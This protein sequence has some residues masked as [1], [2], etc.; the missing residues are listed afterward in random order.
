MCDILIGL[1]PVV[2]FAL[3]EFT[4]HAAVNILLS[5]AVMVLAEFV[6]VLIK[7]WGP[8]DNEKHP[9]KEKFL[10]AL[11]GY[12]INNFLVPS[13]SAVIFALLMPAQN[14]TNPG[15]IYFIIVLGALFGIIIGK[16]VFGGTGQNIFNPAAVGFIFTKI[17][18]PG[19]F[20]SSSWYAASTYNVTAG[21]TY[22][23]DKTANLSVLDLFLGHSDG[24]M[25]EICKY[26]ILIGLVYLLIRHTVD[27]RVVLSF[28]GTFA[29]YLAIESA[30]Y[31]G[32]HQAS[33]GDF[34]L[35]QLLSGGVIFGGV[36]MLTDPVTMPVTRPSRVMYGI[37][38]A[39]STIF[40]RAF[41][42]APEGMAYS[43]LIGNMLAPVMDYYKWSQTRFTWKYLLAMGIVLLIGSGALIWA[44]CDRMT[45]AYTPTSLSILLGGN[46]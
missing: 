12:S 2:I 40:I 44:L 34:F 41:A 19:K 3:I 35:K 31:A 43:I 1:S 4:W 36:Y 5:V 33:F 30:I 11:K 38:V 23:S 29:F 14:T 9:F 15:D 25:G 7:N 45:G 42:S 20:N 46:F 26:A 10:F 37:V 27:W 18:F 32:F 13:V 24:A 39:T 17:C 8:K 16:L 28:F 6:F 21:A 22:L